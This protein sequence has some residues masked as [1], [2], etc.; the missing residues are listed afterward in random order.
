TAKQW[1]DMG[2]TLNPAMMAQFGRWTSPLG[3]TGADGH[4]N[5]TVFQVQPQP[6]TGEISGYTIN[7]DWQKLRYRNTPPHWNQF[8]WGISLD[9]HIAEVHA[10]TLDG[11][12]VTLELFTGADALPQ[13]FRAGQAQQDSNTGIYTLTWN[14]DHVAVTVNLKIISSPNVNGDGTARRGLVGTQLP[15]RAAGATMHT[16]DTGN[17]QTGDKS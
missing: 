4:D 14:H 12:D 5:R 8:V 10:T 3:Q 1:A 15:S 6:A 13:L 11:R 7:I 9:T 17:R 16:A 2:I